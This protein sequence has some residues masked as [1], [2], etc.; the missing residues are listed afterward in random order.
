MLDT[1]VIL[2]AGL[3]SRFG[4][5]TSHMPKGFVEFGGSPMII[6]S[7]ETL[8]KN[9]IRNILI[10]TGYQSEYYENLISSYPEIECYKVD[11][12]YE[13]GN[14]YTL[15]K[16]KELINSDFI[17]LESDIIY[18]EKAI[19]IMQQTHYKNA[20]LGGALT[21]FQAQY[22][23]SVGDSDQLLGCSMS[24]D[25]LTSIDGEFV[26]INKISIELYR[27]M[28]DQFAL[29]KGAENYLN[30]DCFI[31]YPEIRSKFKVI[32]EQSLVWYEIDDAS[33]LDYAESNISL[34]I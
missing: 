25:T 20:V 6:R 3:G 22:Y 19:Q 29:I 8:I 30:Y 11:R 23:L 32:I 5:V 34:N 24:E 7:I 13:T 31:N 28:C 14:M 15:Y 17:L 4:E 10:G 27:Y 16:G 33:D 21:K 18:E 2:A 9:G 1:A 26:G 12:F